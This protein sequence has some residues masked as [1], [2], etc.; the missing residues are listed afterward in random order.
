MKKIIYFIAIMTFFGIH[1]LCFADAPHQI[2]GFGVGT[3]I[4]QY[5]ESLRMDT[6]L[7][8]R[9]MEYLSE[10][11]VKP[12]E[13]FRSGYLSYG[14]CHEPGQIVKIKLKYERESRKFFNELLERFKK[15]FGE[16]SEYK[17][18]AFRAFVAWKWSFTDKDNNKISLILQH[19]RQNDEEYTSGNSVK[20][21]QITLIQKERQCYEKKHP[22]VKESAE[23]MQKE[24][25]AKSPD[26]NLLVPQ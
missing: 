15:K 20:I 14:N 4:K 16:P 22:E 25:S 23:K 24:S 8:I 9:H 11:E 18:D 5:A 6:S 13:G 3:N 12:R 21:S 7:P 2:G 26:F 1:P 10:V 17:G 19:N